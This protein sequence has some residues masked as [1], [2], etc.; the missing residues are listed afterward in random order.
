LA[1]PKV[2]HNQEPLGG[3]SRGGPSTDARG[4]R[5]RPPSDDPRGRRPLRR[6]VVGHQVGHPVNHNHVVHQLVPEGPHWRGTAPDD[7]KMFDIITRRY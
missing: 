1:Q 3:R 4:G 2:Q 6:H 7:T 5:D